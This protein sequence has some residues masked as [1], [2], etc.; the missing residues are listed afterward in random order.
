MLHLLA[1]VKHGEIIELLAITGKTPAVEMVSQHFKREILRTL[2]SWSENLLIVSA[3]Q[4]LVPHCFADRQKEA[5]QEPG[6]PE[7]LGT[8]SAGCHVSLQFIR[9]G[10]STQIPRGPSE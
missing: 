7:C 9:G 4:C 3:A 6:M 8:E 5:G 2:C 10:M 1:A